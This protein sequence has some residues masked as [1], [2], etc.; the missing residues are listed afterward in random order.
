MLLNNRLEESINELGLIQENITNEILSPEFRKDIHLFL[1]YIYT[2]IK[3]SLAYYDKSEKLNVIIP[4]L[5]EH[6]ESL[7]LLFHNL[8]FAY[9]PDHVLLY[10]ASIH[11]NKVNF[12]FFN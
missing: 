9:L 8:S 4:K 12:N 10:Y 11:G 5:E 7:Q 6:L 1:N 3:S 2:F